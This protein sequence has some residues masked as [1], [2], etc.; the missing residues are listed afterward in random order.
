MALFSGLRSVWLRGA[1]TSLASR[2]VSTTCA[3]SAQTKSTTAQDPVQK[4]FLEKMKEY[5]QKS[6]GGSL[7]DSTPAFEARYKEEMEKV[8]RQFGG[9]ELDKFPQFNFKDE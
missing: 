1:W 5:K 7:P 4:L 9:G 6:K 8:K 2:N 3:V